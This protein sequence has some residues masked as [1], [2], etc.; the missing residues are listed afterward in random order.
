MGAS[1]SAA[2]LLFELKG[3]GIT[4]QAQGDRLRFHPR[5]AVGPDL[6][7]KMREHKADIIRLLN[8]E[9]DSAKDQQAV[10]QPGRLHLPDDVLDELLNWPNPP[11]EAELQARGQEILRNIA[12]ARGH[13]KL[14]NAAEAW[15]RMR[16]NF[17]NRNFQR[18]N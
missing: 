13:R 3:R 10:S 18:R 8:R 12:V 14:A 9:A 15:D 16:V 6:L 11:T 2:V 17:R 7:A 1:M 5:S 4:L